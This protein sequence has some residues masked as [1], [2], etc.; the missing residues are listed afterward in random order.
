[1]SLRDRVLELDA[2]E[3]RIEVMLAGVK[4]DP[5]QGP[6]VEEVEQSNLVVIKGFVGAVLLRSTAEDPQLLWPHLE[7]AL[8]AD[9]LAEPEIQSAKDLLLAPLVGTPT[10]I[11]MRVRLMN[12]R[13]PWFRAQR[14]CSEAL[15]NEQGQ[16]EWLLLERMR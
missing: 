11:L 9:L 16:V 2:L 1:M 10:E 6:W 5:S 8:P 3:R 13:G 7:S 15:T 14:A 12:T 4:A